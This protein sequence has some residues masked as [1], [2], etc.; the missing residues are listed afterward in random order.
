MKLGLV[1]LILTSQALAYRGIDFPEGC[2]ER[3]DLSQKIIKISPAPQKLYNGLYITV[4]TGKWPSD[5]PQTTKFFSKGEIDKALGSKI[6]GYTDNALVAIRI[7]QTLEDQKMQAMLPKNFLDM[8][9][10][11]KR[12]NLPSNIIKNSPPAGEFHSGLEL[13]KGSGRYKKDNKDNIRF[14]SRSQMEKVLET[15]IKKFSEKAI[16]AIRTCRTEKDKAEQS[17]TLIKASKKKSI[18]KYNNKLYKS[19]EMMIGR[20]C[21][22]EANMMKKNNKRTPSEVTLN[23]AL[24]DKVFHIDARYTWARTPEGPLNQYGYVNEYTLIPT[25][26]NNTHVHFDAITKKGRQANWFLDL[27]NNKLSFYN[28]KVFDLKRCKDK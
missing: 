23:F 25:S 4:G 10:C 9:G 17:Q 16:F 7:C 3:K 6:L 14:F 24:K 11:V 22:Q 18:L 28:N 2:I 26:R 15:K 1:L 12:K 13:Q 8:E 27:K 19:F 5:K 21:A 20:W